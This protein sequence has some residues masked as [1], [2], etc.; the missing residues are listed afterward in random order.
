MIPV[1]KLTHGRG[2]GTDKACLATAAAM[3]NGEPGALDRPSCVCPVIAGFIWPT[4]DMMDP[5][6]LAEFY[7]PLPWEIIGTAVPGVGD[8]VTS[9]YDSQIL[10][11]RANLAIL[12]AY[13]WLKYLAKYAAPE[14]TPPPGERMDEIIDFCGR[15]RA[16]TN[17]RHSW[18]NRPLAMCDL[19]DSSYHLRN[20]ALICRDM[21][22]TCGGR[23]VFVTFYQS[24]SNRAGCCLQ[25]ISHSIRGVSGRRL[26]ADCVSTIR[27]MCAIG[28][29]RP[30]EPEYKMT[31]EELACALGGG[32][33]A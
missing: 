29:S 8:L 17:H 27:A 6:S 26:Y 2:N 9:P 16:A 3:L 11:A 24:L 1:I 22:L 4:N 33:G 13:K 7:G 21:A 20:A 25:W 5:N 30:K 14:V 31:R 32:C 28:D 10:A 19:Y 18:A 23:S 12:T 15:L